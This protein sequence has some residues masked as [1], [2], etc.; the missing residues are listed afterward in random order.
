MNQMNDYL[1]TFT[2]PN[3]STPS[4]L[5]QHDANATPPMGDFQT[6]LLEKINL[7]KQMNQ[8]LHTNSTNPLS[9]F[10]LPMMMQSTSNLYGQNNLQQMH[11]PRSEERRVGKE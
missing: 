8:Q 1:A 4:I 6:M 10:F 5:P 11:P 9:A 7:A 2:L 3:V